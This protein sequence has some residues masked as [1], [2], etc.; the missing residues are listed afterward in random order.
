MTGTGVASFRWLA[1]LMLMVV[2]GFHAEARQVREIRIKLDLDRDAFN[3]ENIKYNRDGFVLENFEAFRAGDQI[4]YSGIWTEGD[5][6]KVFLHIGLEKEEYEQILK[7]AKTGDLKPIRVVVVG[8]GQQ[9]VYSVLLIEDTETDWIESHAMTRDEISKL[10]ETHGAE[11]Y[12]IHDLDMYSIGDQVYYCGIWEKDGNSGYPVEFGV[13]GAQYD[14]RLEKYE[15]DNYVVEN[16]SCEVVED[17]VIYSTTW[18]KTIKGVQNKARGIT[19]EEFEERSYK[20]ES[21][22]RPNAD[23]CAVMIADHSIYTAT[24]PARRYE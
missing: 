22:Y 2:V 7:D 8:I 10:M 1:V 20:A 19:G 16:I 6:E 18:R 23:F 14:I 21:G 11:G 12:S 17:T 15:G 4:R 9:A 3:E 24:W 13:F 5:R